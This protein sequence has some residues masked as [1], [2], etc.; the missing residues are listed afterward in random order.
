MFRKITELM[1]FKGKNEALVIS[2]RLRACLPIF[3]LALACLVGPR[4]AFAAT[5]YDGDWSV[6]IV[7]HTGAC[8]PTFRYGVQIA[9]G[10]VINDGGGTATVQGRVTQR[11]AVRVIVQSGGQWADGSGRLTKYRGGGV[12]RGRGT[13]GTCGGTWVAERHG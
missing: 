3:A 4:T 8:E 13:S 6:V 10:M 12:W 9:D 5:K 2:K 7:T 1:A 11:G